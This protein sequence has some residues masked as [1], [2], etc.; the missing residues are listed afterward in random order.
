MGIWRS[1]D[2]QLLLRSL[3]LLA[4]IMAKRSTDSH[5]RHGQIIEHSDIYIRND[6]DMWY[7]HPTESK[8]NGPMISF[9]LGISQ[10][11]IQWVA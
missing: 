11:I 8:Q 4:Q 9:F 7:G 5:E 1:A 6:R 10:Y 2:F 3:L